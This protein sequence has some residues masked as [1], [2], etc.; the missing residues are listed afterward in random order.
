[1]KNLHIKFGACLLIAAAGFTSCSKSK[2]EVTPITPKVL[3][4]TTL[5]GSTTAGSLDG[6][7]IASSFKN[8]SGLIFSSDGTLYVGDWANN[9]IRKVNVSTG[10]V[11]RYAGTVTPGF[12]DGPLAS[13]VFNGTANLT[14]DKAGNL[15]IADEE[16]NAIRE[17]TTAGTVVTIAG[18]GAQGANDGIGTAAT[19]FHPEGIVA[20]GNGNLY[21]ADNNN[22]IRKININTKQVTTY[23]GTGIRG[24]KDGPVANAQFSSP[25]GLALDANGDLY[26]GDIVN[27]RIRKITI[28]TGTVSTFAGT[29]TQGLTNGTAL[30]STFYF[31]CGLTFDSSGNLFVAEL[32]NNTIRKIATDGT[33]TTY[34]G[35][36]AQ[37]STDGPATSATFYQPIGLAVDASG[38]V[39]VADE[40]NN[41]LRK[42]SLK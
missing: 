39:Y 4:V 5:A 41:E 24:F 16:N 14:F 17:I 42:I 28:S 27:N 13:A 31:P 8:L 20:D 35:T 34:A 30:S 19:F 7:G 10:A 29:G 32:R 12:T 37:G 23:A 9:L 36:G 1:M 11:T 33:V 18:S 38:N 2:K 15:F 6:T 40:Y 25:Y 26:V 3:T 21:V 22:T